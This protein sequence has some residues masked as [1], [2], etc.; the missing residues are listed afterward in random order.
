MAAVRVNVSFCDLFWG[1]NESATFEVAPLEAP[2]G[3]HTLPPTVRKKEKE[4]HHFFRSGIPEQ[5]KS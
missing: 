3:G 2:K 4:R 5:K 1:L